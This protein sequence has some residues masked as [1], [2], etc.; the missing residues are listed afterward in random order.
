MLPVP[1]TVERTGAKIA[2]SDTALTRLGI[3][4]DSEDE[5]P[6]VEELARPSNASAWPLAGQEVPSLERSS[7]KPPVDRYVLCSIGGPWAL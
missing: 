3:I 5:G 2:H 6:G 4:L 7:Q 1:L